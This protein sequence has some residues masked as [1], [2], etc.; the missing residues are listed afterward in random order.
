MQQARQIYTT[1]FYRSRWLGR[2]IARLALIPSVVAP[3]LRETRT[4]C[5]PAQRSRL[6][7]L[8]YDTA[9][10]R[11]NQLLL[12]RINTKVWCYKGSHHHGNTTPV[13]LHLLYTSSGI[14]TKVV[15]STPQGLWLGH[16]LAR[17]NGN[18]DKQSSNHGITCNLAWHARS[19]HWMYLQAHNNQK[20]QGK[21]TT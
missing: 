5:I 12:Q 13:I 14:T 17:T 6:S 16:D 20:H 3:R 10:H 11:T 21:T 18:H 7:L 8:E 15:N 9:Q 2:P 1:D 19:V 4:P